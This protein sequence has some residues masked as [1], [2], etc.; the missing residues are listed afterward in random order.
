MIN[1]TNTKWAEQ[2]ADREA[3]ADCSAV[4]NSATLKR[5]SSPSVKARFQPG[6]IDE[7]SF[8]GEPLLRHV[9][10]CHVPAT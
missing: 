3:G 1:A 4:A 2:I 8:L 9:S 10:R 5:F 6:S 7:V